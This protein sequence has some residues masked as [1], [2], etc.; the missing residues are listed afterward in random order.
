MFVAG[1][2]KEKSS[3]SF[4][5]LRVGRGSGGVGDTLEGVSCIFTR[6]SA[7]GLCVGARLNNPIGTKLVM[8]WVAVSGV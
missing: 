3:C 5:I 1:D 7:L 6:S 4:S 2:R 8:F